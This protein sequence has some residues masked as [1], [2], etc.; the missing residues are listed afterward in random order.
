MYGCP[1]LCP[2]PEVRIERNAADMLI[3]ISEGVRNMSEEYARIAIVTGAT[4]GIGE[5]TARLFGREG[6]KFFLK[7]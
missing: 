6:A 7:P 4:S 5:A 1:I 3:T 2:L